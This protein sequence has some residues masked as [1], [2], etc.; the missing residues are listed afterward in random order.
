MRLRALHLA[1]IFLLLAT[2]S[3]AEA[4]VLHESASPLRAHY[5]SI[6]I[7]Q[8]EAASVFT[9]DPLGPG[10]REALALDLAP[11]AILRIARTMPPPSQHSV[12]THAVTGSSL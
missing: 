4:S 3:T 1:G 5:I 10:K 11:S 2:L 7:A 12:H 9:E 6:L 8:Q